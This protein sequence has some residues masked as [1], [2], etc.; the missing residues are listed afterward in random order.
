LTQQ[1]H[2]LIVE[3]DEISAEVARV[4]LEKLG[5]RTVIAP[6]GADAI[7]RFQQSEYDLILMDW[8]MPVMNGFEATP[9]IRAMQHGQVTPI[10]ATTAQ[11]GRGEC[12]A[13]GMND[14]MPKPF[15]MDT[16]RQMLAKWTHWNEE[17]AASG[18]SQS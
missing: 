18:E 13:A 3:D 15:R 7:E 17:R 4:M 5:C 10:I 2:V 6:N 12:L 9:R 16:L 14:L 8:Q 11:M 1:I